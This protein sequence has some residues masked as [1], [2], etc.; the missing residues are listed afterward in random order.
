MMCVYVYV[1]E[2]ACVC[3][4]RCVCVDVICVDMCV[5]CVYVY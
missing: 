1:C 3:V 4:L 5:G 2:S